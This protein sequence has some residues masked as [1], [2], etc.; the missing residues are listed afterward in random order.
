MNDLTNVFKKI[1]PT[2]H[3]IPSIVEETIL[4]NGRYMLL[5]F[6]LS[7]VQNI[8]VKFSYATDFSFNKYRLKYFDSIISKRVKIIV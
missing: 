3:E 2:V 7:Y 5:K 4:P 8:I 6:E 1:S